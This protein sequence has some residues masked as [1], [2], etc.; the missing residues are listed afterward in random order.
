MTLNPA[1]EAFALRLRET[2]PEQVFRSPEPRYMEEPRGRWAGQCGVLALPRSVEEVSALVAAAAAARVPVVPYGGGTGLVGGQVMPEGPAPMIVS[3]ER[4]NA[5][6][7]IY[8]T[9]NVMIAEAGAILADV[10]LA[11]AEA[12]R[13]FPLSLAAEGTA[14]IGGNLS[15]NAG[16][17]AVLR[18][19]NARDL[20]LGLEA[21]LPDG[22]IWHGLS[23]LRKDNTGYD[24]RNLLVGAEGT[25][26]IITAATLKLY[27]QPAARGTAIFVV[28]DP[29]AAIE[30][31]AMARD[32]LGE[33]VSA[34]E[35]IAGQGL[36]FLAETLPDVRQPFDTPPDWCVLIELGLARGLDPEAALADLFEAAL[37][38]GLANDGLIA[39]SQAQRDD[40]WSVRE[41]IPEGNRRIGAVSSHDISVPISLIPEFIARGNQ[42]VAGLG[43]FRVNCFGH[44]GDG[45]LH[46]NVFPE[47]GRSKA[48]HANQV[49]AVKRAVHDLV[50]EM[51][52][53][54]SAEHGIG[55]LKVED[56]ERYSDPV[57]LDALRAIKAA[58][59]PLGIMNPGAVLRT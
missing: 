2:L 20:C 6:R 44:L 40:F 45:N 43:G 14:R 8:P 1:D 13:L 21:V 31:L 53:S 39:Q 22:R 11:A 23:R 4:M 51:G 56:L 9:E 37:E 49:G 7:G 35:L 47:P 18:Y 19:G 42:I 54:V 41:H 38:A 46:Y 27:P 5:I 17:T 34:F 55:R 16:G 28:R 33:G 25:L 12:G 29:Q 48:D 58:L 59:D 30:L 57:R 10:Q 15:T 24:L 32:Q 3:L 26:G 50:H 52:G 36:R